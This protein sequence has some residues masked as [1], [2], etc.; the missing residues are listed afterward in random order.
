MN[1]SKMIKKNANMIILVIGILAAGYAFS[2]YN[3]KFAIK[4]AMTGNSISSNSGSVQP[5]SGNDY[6]SANGLKT[7]TYGLPP[8]CAK[9]EVVNP[10]ELLP[11]D[12]N[13]EFAKLNPMGSGDLKNVNL[14]QA[15]HHIGINLLINIMFFK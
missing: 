13:S 9:K 6:V 11:R 1:I 15:G 12:T 3:N 7:D 14:L 10:E 8:S 4:S 2:C 5:S